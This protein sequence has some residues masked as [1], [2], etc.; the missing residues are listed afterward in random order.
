[1]LSSTNKSKNLQQK[2]SNDNKT[3]L[4]SKIENKLAKIQKNDQPIYLKSQIDQFQ[5]HM[6]I[7]I[8]FYFLSLKNTLI[9]SNS[10]Q[11]SFIH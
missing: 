1:M 9:Y 2:A 5:S 6:E 7:H 10:Q 8:P 4:L 11:M 3:N